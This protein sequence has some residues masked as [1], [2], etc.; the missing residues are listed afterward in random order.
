MKGCRV[1]RTME[2]REGG[3]RVTNVIRI[4]TYLKDDSTVASKYMRL[5]I[6]Y[7]NITKPL[8]ASTVYLLAVRL[9][10]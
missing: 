7:F 3:E 9:L 6:G 5:A 1:I 4:I 2:I 10:E 8:P